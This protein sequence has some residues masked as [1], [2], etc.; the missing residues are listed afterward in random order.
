[1]G[2]IQEGL[3][4]RLLGLSYIYIGAKIMNCQDCHTEIP[5]ARLA[6]VPDTK[7]CVKCADKHILPKRGFVSATCKSK[8]W[9]LVVE[10]GDSGAAKTWD[11]RTQLWEKR[12]L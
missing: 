11:R 6:A 8:G 2:R 3:G 10:D 5:E 1:M 12:G 9:N 7:W 4:G